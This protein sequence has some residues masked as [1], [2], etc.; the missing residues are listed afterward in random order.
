MNWTGRD[1]R[2]EGQLG[3]CDLVLASAET[4]G[5]GIEDIDW[6]LFARKNHMDMGTD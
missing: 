3:G 6:K 1:Q 5:I 4:I 2:Q